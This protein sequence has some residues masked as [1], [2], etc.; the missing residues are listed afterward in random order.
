MRG[1][2][3]GWVDLKLQLSNKVSKNINTM[4]EHAMRTEIE[5]LNYEQVRHDAFIDFL[6]L[7]K[8]LKR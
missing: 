3:A 8:I 7:F 1:E 4:D 6:P 5:F 2:L